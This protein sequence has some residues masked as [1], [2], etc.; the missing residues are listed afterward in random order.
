MGRTIAPAP[1]SI[2]Y[3]PPAPLHI[4]VERALLAAQAG[5]CLLGYWSITFSMLFCESLST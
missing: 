4:D 3:L 2:R 1:A 5:D